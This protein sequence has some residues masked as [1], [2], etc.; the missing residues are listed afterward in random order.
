MSASRGDDLTLS[1]ND[2]D[3]AL[4][5][6]EKTE[7]KM[8]RTFAGVGTSKDSQLQEDLMRFIALKKSCRIS[9]IYQAFQGFITSKTQLKDLLELLTDSDFCTR[10]IK[11]K[12]LYVVFNPNSP[13]AGRYKK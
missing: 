9:E 13:V 5:L 6:L 8:A 4:K 12:T 11:G 3:R 2:F 10:V 1:E 7:V